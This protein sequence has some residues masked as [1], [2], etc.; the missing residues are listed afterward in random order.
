M[1]RRSFFTGLLAAPAII[2]ID[3]LMPVRGL[4]VPVK[5]ELVRFKW[6]VHKVEMVPWPGIHVQF[7]NPVRLVELAS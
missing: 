7:E 1:N 4:I 2:S 5:P 6:T 3:R